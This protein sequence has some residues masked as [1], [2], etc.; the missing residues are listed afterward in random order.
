MS[1]RRSLAAK[2]AA[3]PHAERQRIWHSL[4]TVER[5]QLAYE[6]GFWARAEQLPPPGEWSTWLILTGRG[7]E[8]P[9]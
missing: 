5:E 2:L 6:W 3:L 1:G 9:E 7:W 4:S 8:K